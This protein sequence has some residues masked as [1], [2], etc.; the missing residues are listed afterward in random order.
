VYRH[1][2]H[3]RQLRRAAVQDAQLAGN[4]AV[5][6]PV[7]FFI[8]MPLRAV[9]LAYKYGILAAVYIA[10]LALQVYADYRLAQLPASQQRERQQRAELRKVKRR[11]H[12]AKRFN[13][14]KGERP[15]RNVTVPRNGAW[16]L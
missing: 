1:H 12:E 4:L 10:R 15:R 8:F 13:V 9:W 6:W 2:H 14:M 3:H 16:P 11:M 7:R 5:A